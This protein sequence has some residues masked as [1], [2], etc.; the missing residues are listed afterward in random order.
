MCTVLWNYNV[1]FLDQLEE[2][3]EEVAEVMKK[4]KA[5]VSQLS[6]DQI[7][8]SEQSQQIAELE[9]EKQVSCACLVFI[10]F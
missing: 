7:T 6:V 4:Y 2:S 8:L 1:P 3:E 9:H 5:V 10:V